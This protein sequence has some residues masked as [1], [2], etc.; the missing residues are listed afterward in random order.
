MKKV[1]FLIS[2]LILVLLAGCGSRE[3]KEP[4]PEWPERLTGEYD[5]SLT[6]TFMGAEPV[7]AGQDTLTGRMTA[8]FSLEDGGTL[9]LGWRRL[10]GA[11]TE[12]LEDFLAGGGTAGAWSAD[13]S[14]PSAAESYVSLE[15][16][17]YCITASCPG[18]D[19][20]AVIDLVDGTVEAKTAKE[21][22]L[23]GAASALWLTDLPWEEEWTGLLLG[24]WELD[25]ET[26][27]E[28]L[29]TLFNSY[30]WLLLDPEAPVEEEFIPIL[31]RWVVPTNR[32]T[33][34]YLG[35][36]NPVKLLLRENGDLYWNGALY[37]PL[38]NGGGEGLLAA[39]T[40]LGEN[41]ENTAGPPLLTL[42]CGEESITAITHVSYSWN[43][44]ARMGWKT[45]VES[46]A[47]TIAGM[48]WFADGAPVL[49]ADGEVTLHFASREP[50]KLS[51]FTVFSALGR[52]P[53]EL[54]DWRFTPYAGRNA[55]LLSCTWKR[56]NQGGTDSASYILLIEGAETNAPAAA[57]TEELSLTVT[58]ADRYSCAY[59]LED[60]GSRSC[61]LYGN[62]TLLRRNAAGGLEWI[63]PRRRP[64]DFCAMEA[65][66]GGT[67]GRVWDW[68]HPYGTLEAGDYCLQLRG[69]LGRGVRKE[70]VCLRADF[71][72]G[73]EAPDGPGYPVFC[74]VPWSITATLGKLSSHRYV[75]TL[76][77]EQTNWRVSRDFSLFRVQE[78]GSL[79]YIPPEYRLPD[80]LDRAWL[81]AGREN[82]FDVD[83]A[84]QYGELSAGEYV[85]RRAFYSLELDDP[86]R[87][88]YA[89]PRQ[90]PEE[91]IRYGDMRLTIT[92]PLLDV[93]RG[94]D[95]L[96]ERKGYNGEE[97][98]VLVST[99]GSRFTSTEAR[100]RLELNSLDHWYDVEFE[101]DYFYLYFC[102][103]GEWYPVEHIRYASH[104]LLS[105]T[106]KPG[107]AVEIEYRFSPLFGSLPAGLYRMVVSCTAL[108]YAEGAER[109]D[110]LI[111]VEFRIREDGTGI[112]QGLGEAENLIHLY[113][114]DLGALYQPVPEEVSARFSQRWTFPSNDPYVNGWRLERSKDRLLVTVQRD[115][116]LD[117]ARTLLGGNPYV[118]VVRAEAEERSPS[119][120]TAENLGSRGTLEL[121]TLEQP[122]PDLYREGFRLLRF[123][124]TGEETDLDWSIPWYGGVSL[125]EYDGSAASW[126]RLDA[127]KEFL[128]LAWGWASRSTAE[129][130]ELA[131]EFMLRLYSV[132]EE[133]SPEKEYRIVLSVRT[134]SDREKTLEYYTCPLIV[135]EKGQT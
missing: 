83:L 58:R 69:T 30:N 84:A 117:R 67:A 116:E 1:L 135:T 10:A 29:H 79:R 16:R 13:T 31:A 73:D 12:L 77:T 132:R 100:L 118:E 91:R 110:G 39:W 34:I 70:D 61:V 85:I 71:T 66:G 113:A 45:V 105:R 86:D 112:W 111:A 99:Q 7:S 75:Q 50:E 72:L 98:T 115:R 8:L 42:T 128:Y 17:W 122:D 41:G 68:S 36:K 63:P 101:S 52:S 56:T 87:A 103:K 126:N 123:I 55:Y 27:K 119:P 133:F 47:E 59:T 21:T 5:A 23:P 2:I 11:E 94:V 28:A 114:Q 54:K 6:F 102:H 74:N 127:D 37:R 9:A 92:I 134:D 109:R 62:Y 43:H 130:G 108:P 33:V 25:P 78:D 81:I 60:L 125:E 106:L 46:D 95:P 4:V 18:K 107:E 26:G 49:Y 82:A 57:E 35:G 80:E 88:L 32:Q 38:G 3:A 76:T 131:L 19:V 104:G 121:V 51:S 48:D 22:A 20:Q 97:S 124:W 90:V 96:D 120:V 93:P 44:A 65:E 53:V 129:P 89:Y 14:A 15:G 24:H 40:A 64:M